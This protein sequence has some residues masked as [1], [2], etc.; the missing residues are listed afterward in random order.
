MKHKILPPRQSIYLTHWTPE[1]IEN[2]CKISRDWLRHHFDELPHDDLIVTKL[3][4]D[5]VKNLFLVD[6]TTL[7]EDADVK[8]I[9]Y[10]SYSW[11]APPRREWGGKDMMV[12][13]G[14]QDLTSEQRIAILTA[15]AN[16]TGR[17]L[18]LLDLK[19]LTQEE[20]R[21]WIEALSLAAAA[22]RDAT[23][24]SLLIRGGDGS[25]DAHGLLSAL[26]K[27]KSLQHL[28][29]HFMKI[30]D[31]CIE[32]LSHFTSLISLHLQS[33]EISAEFAVK[34]AGLH[35]SDSPLAASLHRLHIY[36]KGMD[37]RKCT[38]FLHHWQ[39]LKELSLESSGNGETDLQEFM[40]HL[41]PAKKEVGTD[42]RPPQLYSLKLGLLLSVEFSEATIGAM[43][44]ALSRS[45]LPFFEYYHSP[46]PAVKAQLWRNQR[47]FFLGS[48]LKRV[49]ATST[50]LF[51]C[52]DP[53][54]G[55]KRRRKT[56]NTSRLSNF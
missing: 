51:I 41:A 21:A 2:A 24:Q 8:G 33:V 30:S 4:M 7:R 12:D 23:P 34:L 46:D 19:N 44:D 52:G 53:F 5:N 35:P 38:G 26:K 37:W 3:S 40:E 29:L 18:H 14:G 56:Q 17:T 48:D 39:N 20:N 47:N 13:L 32:V 16:L 27:S 42:A 25:M 22:D 10:P 54:A 31:E 43:V 28:S 50:R 1:E 6:T 49:P 9:M 36:S 11:S 45:G 55:K 15:A